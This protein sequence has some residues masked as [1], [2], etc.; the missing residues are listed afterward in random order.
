M[1]DPIQVRIDVNPPNA[2]DRME[3]FF[4]NETFLRVIDDSFKV[5][6]SFIAG[7]VVKTKLS[8]QRLNRRTGILANSITGGTVIRNKLPALTIGIFKGPA[9]A[10]AAV[11]EFGT[12]GAGG[13]LPTIRP[14]KAKALSIP[15]GAHALTPSG[16]SRFDSPRDYVG[17]GELIFIPS[18]TS[19]GVLVD[20]VTDINEVGDVTGVQYVLATKVDIPPQHYLYDTMVQNLPRIAQKVADQI[21]L[22]FQKIMIRG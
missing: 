18:A 13:T 12:V 5:L 16:V 9:L 6:S 19:V 3:E 1:A 20:S 14:K 8:G 15:V 4:S 10:Y 7:Q 17:P 2:L 22:E 21:E 11:Q